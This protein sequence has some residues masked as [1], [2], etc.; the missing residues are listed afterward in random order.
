M[1]NETPEKVVKLEETCDGRV[2]RTFYCIY[3]HVFDYWMSVEPFN[4]EIW[5]RDP[6]CRREFISREAAADCLVRLNDWR[7]TGDPD[8]LDEDESE[9]DAE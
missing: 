8:L 4:S 9:D 3:D 6:A 5:T 2:V 1:K 7:E